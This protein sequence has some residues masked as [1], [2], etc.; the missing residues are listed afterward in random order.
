MGRFL[1]RAKKV[2]QGNSLDNIK[3]LEEQEEV[4][5]VIIKFCESPE[6]KHI[7]DLFFDEM[8]NNIDEQK[9]ALGKG[10]TEKATYLAGDIGRLYKIISLSRDAKGELNTLENELKVNREATN[11]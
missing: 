1:N 3:Q 11:G 7:E 4:T 10:F 8:G 5:K 2:L 9:T 6:W